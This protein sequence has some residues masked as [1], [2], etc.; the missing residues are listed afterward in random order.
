MVM[1][2]V[3]PMRFKESSGISILIYGSEKIG[4]GDKEKM[5]VDKQARC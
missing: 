2:I 4:K 5:K 1:A 3:D